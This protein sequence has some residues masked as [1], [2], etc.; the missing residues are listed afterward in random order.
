[1]FTAPREN[2]PPGYDPEVGEMMGLETRDGH[3]M[4]VVVIHADEKVVKMDGNH[5]LAGKDLTF[6]IELVKIG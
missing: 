5:P 2:L 4:D 1:V 3:Q 6:D